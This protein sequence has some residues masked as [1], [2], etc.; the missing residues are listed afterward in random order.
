MPVNPITCIVYESRRLMKWS[1]RIKFMAA[2]GETLGHQYNR[3]EDAIA[4]AR[5][6]TN[7]EV[8][9]KLEAHY[10]DGNIIQHIRLR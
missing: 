5:L 2:N 4:A 10:R 7:P 8:P 9:C 6:I 1:W 3:L